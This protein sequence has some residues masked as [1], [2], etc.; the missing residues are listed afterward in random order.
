MEFDKLI[1]TRRSM[2]GYDDTKKLTEKDIEK[3]IYSAIQAPSWKNYQTARYH[4]ILS[5]DKIE[6]FKETCLPEFNAK[7][8]NSVSALIITTF[9]KD[10]AGFDKDTALP[11]NELGNGW[12]IY[13][14]GLQNENL[15]LKAKDMGLDTLIMGIR[16]EEKIR[17][18]LS[19]PKNECVVSVIGVGFGNK[20]ASKPKR[21]EPTD[22][23]KFY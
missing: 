12:G 7:N 15:I 1:E 8:C 6:K 23:V 21:K 5:K 4:C 3:L 13:D 10:R 14:L 16:N 9:I 11:V 17:E 19:I 18:M 20:E 22:I 2:R